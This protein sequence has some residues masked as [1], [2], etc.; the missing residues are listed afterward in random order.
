MNTDRAKKN[1]RSLAAALILTEKPVSG[2][3]NPN[4]V[5][6]LSRRLTCLYL[7]NVSSAF[8]NFKEHN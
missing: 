7:C 2:V 1:I 8:V 4:S 6:K 5:G 3:V